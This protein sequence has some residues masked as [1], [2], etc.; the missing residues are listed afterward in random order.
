MK[1]L[2]L[3]LL[4][5]IISVSSFAQK[6]SIAIS[7]MKQL[8][9][10]YFEGDDLK[11]ILPIVPEGA[12]GS[13]GFMKVSGSLEYLGENSE[14]VLGNIP[15]L[16]IFIPSMYL[17]KIN[18]KQFRLVTLT[19]KK[20]KRKLKTVSSS[21]FGAKVG[22]KNETMEMK[23]LSDECYKIYTS[24]PMEEG[25]YGVF[26]NYGGGVPYKLYDFDIVNK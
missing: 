25:H 5:L 10:Y 7:Q 14:N 24:G 19:I 23:K 11:Q 3:T 21:L 9:V 1:T 2:I 6:D 20:G 12:R 22:S 13:V 18:P 26:Y 16:Y 15:E 8:G 17:N 4:G